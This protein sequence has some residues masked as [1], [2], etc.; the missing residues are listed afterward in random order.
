MT[1]VQES[2]SLTSAA[3]PPDLQW[4]AHDSSR[5]RRAYDHISQTEVG[6]VLVDRLRPSDAPEGCPWTLAREI[7]IVVSDSFDTY[8]AFE[9]VL[10]KLN[11]YGRTAGDAKAEL[12]AKLGGHLKLL[13]RLESPS[14][15]PMLRLELEF[16]RAVMRPN[17]D[18]G[19]A[20]T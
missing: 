19:S 6:P 5:P 17:G 4:L 10:N 14:M 9:R 18:A 16:L 13:S 7:P 12:V 20:Q 11:G 2:F 8:W 3:S 1:E 15:A